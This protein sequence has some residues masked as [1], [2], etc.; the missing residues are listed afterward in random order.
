M[1]T[2]LGVDTVLHEPAV[3]RAAKVPFERPADVAAAVAGE[4]AELREPST[5]ASRRYTARTPDW[6]CD[7]STL[8]G[9]PSPAPARCIRCEAAPRA[10]TCAPGAATPTTPRCAAGTVRLTAPRSPRATALPWVT[11]GLLAGAGAAALARRPRLSGAAGAAAAA[12]VVRFWWARVRPR[13]HSPV[14]WLRMAA[15]SALVP[16]S[17]SWWALT[18]RWRS[19]V[20]A[21]ARPAGA[22]PGASPRSSCSAGT[23]R[24]FGLSRQRRSGQGRRGRR[25]DRVL[26]LEARRGGVHPGVGR[27]TR[28]AGRRDVAD[29][30]RDADGVLR[31]PHRAVPVG[32]RR[33]AR[34]PGRPAG[35]EVKE[36][37]V[38]T[39]GEASWP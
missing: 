20:L 33:G 28:G 21:P 14:E 29:T 2:V 16:V 31:R 23:A 30:R 10:T 32:T 11:T 1:V 19:R 6:S 17:A 39:P 37:A 26:R 24:W 34:R 25:R 36:L 18:G 15:S 38:M 3:L 35:I 22:G 5:G 8:P 27:R 12:R 4:L 7:C 9:V 13:P